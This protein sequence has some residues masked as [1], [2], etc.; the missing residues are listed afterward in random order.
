MRNGVLA[1]VSIGLIGLSAGA[2]AF[3]QATPPPA[4]ATPAA[5]GSLP[6]GIQPADSTISFFEFEAE[7]ADV[8]ELP[9]LLYNNDE[10]PIEI[11]TY[12]ADGYTLVNGGFDARLDGQ[13]VTETASWIEYEA[14]NI[15]IEGGDTIERLARLTVPADAAPGE[16][17]AAL[18]VQNAS[19]IQTGNIEQVIRQLIAVVVVIPGSET[20]AI[21]VGDASFRQLTDYF[22][23]LVEVTNSGSIRVRPS[24][25]LAVYDAADT[26]MLT[27][28]V[29]MGLVLPGDT[30]SVEI[31]LPQVLPVGEYI[32]EIL[33]GD[34]ESGLATEYSDRTQT[35]VELPTP[36]PPPT[37]APT[38]S[39]GPTVFFG[40]PTPGAA[41]PA[42]A[43]PAASADA[44][45]A[46]SGIEPGGNV[47]TNDDIALRPAPDPDA[48]PVAEF[49]RG[50]AL[51]VIGPAQEGGGFIWWP[52]S[53][54]AT[55]TTGFVRQEFLSPAP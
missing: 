25:E 40:S 44:P 3:A 37:P 11:R 32:V 36:T 12:A 38:V 15:I 6:Y 46:V 51:L 48:A 52:V 42:A 43:T 17:F 5:G 22:S 55:G 23:V 21:E 20:V 18:V 30:T 49:P 14:E 31:A 19:P 1:A 2:G 39:T 47:V 9:V 41:T 29:T 28:P 7:P 24:G 34:E 53:D 16:Y 10:L 27:A 35:V 13:P 8:V 50:T 26:L 45:P 54:P 33:L 4:V